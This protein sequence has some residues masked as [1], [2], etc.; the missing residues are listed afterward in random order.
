MNWA[1]DEAHYIIT[2]TVFEVLLDFLK[3]KVK[4]TYL[5]I[6]LKIKGLQSNTHTSAACLSI[7]KMK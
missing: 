7:P 1:V 5:G 4:E 3:L 2:R 6:E